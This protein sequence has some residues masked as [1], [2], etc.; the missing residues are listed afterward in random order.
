MCVLY[1]T[2]A[3]F[4]LQYLR[5]IVK[6]ACQPYYVISFVPTLLALDEKIMMSRSTVVY[7]FVLS[8]LIAILVIVRPSENNRGR[9]GGLMEEE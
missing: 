2:V 3:A 7:L 6:S 8:L 1:S 4:F 5:H 9:G